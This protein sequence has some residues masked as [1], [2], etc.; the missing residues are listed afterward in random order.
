MEDNKKKEFKKWCLDV[1]NETNKRD[2]NEDEFLDRETKILKD[3]LNSNFKFDESKRKELKEKYSESEIAK[4]EKETQKLMEQMAWDD[5][6]EAHSKPSETKVDFSTIDWEHLDEFD[7]LNMKQNIGLNKRE[8]QMFHCIWTL[9]NTHFITGLNEDG[10]LKKTKIMDETYHTALKSLICDVELVEKFP[11]YEH[12]NETLLAE[13]HKL[14]DDK[15]LIKKYDLNW[16]DKEAN[17][18]KVGKNSVKKVKDLRTGIVYESASEC[19]NAIGKSNSYIT[20]HRDR[21]QLVN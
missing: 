15:E 10:S 5:W 16:K 4:A 1:F 9:H 18:K 7:M 3:T 11:D 20:K 14:I 2:F 21:F 17:M 8:E 6:F 13:A 12:V 19:A